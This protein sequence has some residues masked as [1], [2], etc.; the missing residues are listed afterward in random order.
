MVAASLAGGISSLEDVALLLDPS[1]ESLY[2][3]TCGG[4]ESSAADDLEIGDDG[5]GTGGGAEIAPPPHPQLSASTSMLA[6][7]SATPSST[8][9]YKL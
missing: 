9:R 7:G 3:L 8:M 2:R 5:D 4:E 1:T 6:A